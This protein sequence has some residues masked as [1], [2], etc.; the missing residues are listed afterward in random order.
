MPQSPSLVG[1]MYHWFT[2]SAWENHMGACPWMDSATFEHG[3]LPSGIWRRYAETLYHQVNGVAV[4]NPDAVPGYQAADYYYNRYG[5]GGT[6]PSD[7]LPANWYLDP[8]QRWLV[9]SALTSSDGMS[10]WGAYQDISG[11]YHFDKWEG[12]QAKTIQCGARMGAGG[13][14]L[15]AALVVAEYALTIAYD[16]Q[17]KELNE[18]VKAYRAAQMPT[19]HDYYGIDDPSLG[20]R[21]V[22]RR[23]V[24]NFSIPSGC[25]SSIAPTRNSQGSVGIRT[26]EVTVP[27][28]GE[29]TQSKSV[30]FNE[31]FTTATVP[32][33]FSIEPSCQSGTPSSEFSGRFSLQLHEYG[34]DW[35]EIPIAGVKDGQWISPW[36]YVQQR[37]GASSWNSTNDAGNPVSTTIATSG[38]NSMAVAWSGQV[39]VRAYDFGVSHFDKMK[40]TA[41]ASAKGAAGGE[42]TKVRSWLSVQPAFTRNI[43]EAGVWRSATPGQSLTFTADTSVLPGNATSTGYTWTMPDGSTVEDTSA[44]YTFDSAGIYDVM[45]KVDPTVPDVA[46][47]AYLFN[48]AAG[49]LSYDICRVT[50][51][52]SGNPVDSSHPGVV[53][54]ENVTVVASSSQVTA[55]FNT[56]QLAKAR[57]WW[58]LV[59]PDFVGPLQP[60]YEGSVTE[61]GVGVNHTLSVPVSAATPYIIQISAQPGGS[62]DPVYARYDG[63]TWWNIMTP[64]AGTGGVG[65]SSATA[66]VSFTAPA[67]SGSP[68]AAQITWTTDVPT[69][70]RVQWSD[71]LSGPPGSA[72]AS[73]NSYQSAYTTNHAATLT[74]LTPGKTYTFYLSGIPQSSAGHVYLRRPSNSYESR[75]PIGHTYQVPLYYDSGSR[76][77]ETHPLDYLT[78]TSQAGSTLQVD[79]TLQASGRIRLK[80]RAYDSGDWITG[81]WVNASGTHQWS[82][83]LPEGPYELVVEGEMP[84]GQ[85]MSSRPYVVVHHDVQTTGTV[86]VNIT[87]ADNDQPLQGIGVCVDSWA[88]TDFVGETDGGGTIT[89]G[90]VPAGAHTVFASE[91]GYDSANQALDVQVGQA[92]NVQLQLAMQ[93]TVYGS[94]KLAEQHRNARPRLP[95]KPVDGGDGFYYADNVTVSAIPGGPSVQSHREQEAA[96]FEQGMK[97]HGFY[98][99]ESLSPGVH[100][101]NISLNGWTSAPWSVNINQP[102][103]TARHDFIIQPA[104][105]QD[106]QQQTR[107]VEVQASNYSPH[108]CSRIAGWDWL[109]GRGARIAFIF[110]GSDFDG[111]DPSRVKLHVNALCTDRASGGAGYSTDLTFDLSATTGRT[112]ERCLV[113]MKNPFGRQDPNLTTGEGYRFTGESAFL[114]ADLIERTIQN[115]HLTAVITWPGDLSEGTDRH[116]AFRKDSLTLV[117]E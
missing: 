15:F 62:G 80:H 55:N 77:G 32:F 81:S 46:P 14:G 18:Q 104:Q 45:L 97:E 76:S 100:T 69:T 11:L 71:T 106:D 89:F 36:S 38:T 40:V 88:N 102:G 39:L 17:V 109:R 101:L 113:K 50:V 24:P 92:H 20:R 85:I 23:K 5:A 29:N 52:Q 103:Q 99:F 91:N 6:M 21:I 67:F 26:P 66:P 57:L 115:G 51:G 44:T 34:G 94:V 111:C 7:Q 98:L 114:P 93:S 31:S 82:L 83:D 116:V 90:N 74:G 48:D 105:Q 56:P 37:D 54:F 61:T 96:E 43:A 60:G 47:N 110:D 112:S 4:P 33:Q 68:G 78:A 13:A 9:W 1:K 8:M 72:E 49:G 84:D 41:T 117:S 30:T 86:S 28:S 58:R 35:H 12:G 25:D 95:R 63:K 65:L 70:T 10:N 42:T 87:R 75:H 53:D 79:A 19:E 27:Q 107:Q 64:T 16:Q 22:V 73:G 3:G 108:F 59:Q 2:V